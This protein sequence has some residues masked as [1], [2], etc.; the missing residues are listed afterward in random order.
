VDY[1]NLDE[2][3][4]VHV[5]REPGD[6][7]EFGDDESVHASRLRDAV[8]GAVSRTTDLANFRPQLK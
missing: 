5:V 2:V 1:A 4:A 3:V 6:V 7:R 8:W